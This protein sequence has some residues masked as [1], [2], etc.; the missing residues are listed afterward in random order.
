MFS[1]SKSSISHPNV[2]VEAGT[3]VVT[4]LVKF[5]VIV[6]SKKLVVGFTFPP[7]VPI[8]FVLRVSCPAPFWSPPRETT[9]TRAFMFF[10]V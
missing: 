9:A 1:T 6:P 4:L 2:L 10:K 7:I 3:R 8:S 5:L